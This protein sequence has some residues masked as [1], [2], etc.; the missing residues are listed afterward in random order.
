MTTSWSEVGS[1][2]M[3]L[4]TPYSDSLQRQRS[5]KPTY[6]C[7]YKF[8]ISCKLDLIKK[9]DD[10]LLPL[11]SSLFSRPCM[12]VLPSAT[13]CRRAFRP[14][15]LNCKFFLKKNNANY[16]HHRDGRAF[17]LVSCLIIGEQNLDRRFI[18]MRYVDYFFLSIFWV[19]MMP[20]FLYLNHHDL[21]SPTVKSVRKG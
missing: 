14:R 20:R 5:L 17:S 11:L 7:M 6:I 10:H 9:Q 15:W 2:L 19:L 16:T 3:L 12:W 13:R 1:F 8:S 4:P 21:I 18:C